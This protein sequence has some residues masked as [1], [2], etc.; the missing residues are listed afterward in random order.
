MT[1]EIVPQDGWTHVAET[2]NEAHKMRFYDDDNVTI[3]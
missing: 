3:V 2:M 1:I